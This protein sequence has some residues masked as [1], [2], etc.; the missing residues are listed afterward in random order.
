MAGVPLRVARPRVRLA[1]SDDER[2]AR[3]ERAWQ[4]G[5]LF[6]PSREFNDLGVNPVANETFGDFVRDKIRSIVDDPETAE[7]LCPTDHHFGTK[8]PCLD[9]NYYET[10]NLPHVRLVDLRAGPDH[11]RDGNRYRHRRASRSS[12]M[13]SC[14]QPVSTP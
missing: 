10:F 13:R 7:T 11:H 8:R 1:V 4:A 3:F 6:A 5:E 12:S 9:T 14:T 2:Q